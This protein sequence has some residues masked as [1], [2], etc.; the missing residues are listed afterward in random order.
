MLMSRCHTTIGRGPKREN[1][2]I[3][4]LEKTMVEN[5]SERKKINPKIKLHNKN[6]KDALFFF[7]PVFWVPPIWA[8]SDFEKLFDRYLIGYVQNCNMGPPALGVLYPCKFPAPRM[9]APWKYTRENIK[10]AP[11]GHTFISLLKNDPTPRG[12]VFPTRFQ[13]R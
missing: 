3:A 5:L 2:K 12:D 1:L 10:T 8:R 7:G 4:G 9:S 6:Q 13:K 11:G